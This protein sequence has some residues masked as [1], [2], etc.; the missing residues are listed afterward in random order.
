[1]WTCVALQ[2]HGGWKEFGSLGIVSSSTLWLWKHVLCPPGKG[3]SCSLSQFMSV[4]GIAVAGHS[5][6]PLPTQPHLS[7]HG[8][9]R[10]PLILLHLHCGE[11]YHRPRALSSTVH[12]FHYGLQDFLHPTPTTLNPRMGRKG[13]CQGMLFFCQMI[14][15]HLVYFDVICSWLTDSFLNAIGWT[16]TR[17]PL[18][19]QFFLTSEDPI[20]SVP[21]LLL[22]YLISSHLYSSH[23]FLT[24]FN[25][26]GIEKESSLVLSLQVLSP[27]Y[28]WE[29]SFMA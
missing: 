8:C 24:S 21:Y 11:L 10:F 18:C 17:D 7:S 3:W 4:A 20:L 23:I 15:F 16:R 28:Q 25:L 27:F 6:P 5:G 13:N 22:L 1:M 9:L 26:P 19:S 2:P 29:A 12:Y 14:L